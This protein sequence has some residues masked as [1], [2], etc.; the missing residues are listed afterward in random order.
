MVY[1]HYGD[2]LPVVGVL[3]R[4]LNECRQMDVRL[5]GVEELVED[6]V[7]GIRTRTAF[8]DAQ[9]ALGLRD[10]SGVVGPVTW[11]QLA[12]IGGFRIVDVVDAVFEAW[13]Q[14]KGRAG[15][16]WEQID[17]YMKKFP[18]RSQSDAV[19]FADRAIRSMENEI[20]DNRNQYN[21][22]V[23]H[24]GRPIAITSRE[25]VFAAIRKGLEERCRDGNRVV[26]LRF[27][28]HGGPGSQGVAATTS[29]RRVRIT[30]DTLSFDD[31]DTPEELVETVVL[32]GMTMPMAS[33]GCVELHGCNVGARRRVGR[34]KDRILVNGPAYVQNFANTVG[35][36]VSASAIG[37]YF[38]TLK[39]DV[40]Y[41]GAV[42][43]CAPGGASVRDWFK[44]H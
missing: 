15:L 24:G 4:V 19:A 2:R 31:D 36:P 14:K 23:T 1:L 29:A 18:H 37:D 25:H 28:A 22:L 6:G 17:L 41:E 27:T 30:D 10:Q 13:M 16:H 42:V 32:S 33:F 40:R 5:F 7:F 12:T 20:K 35:R 39:L 9:V 44:Q 11:R 43:S 38:G 26:L 34:G 3:Q 8:Q 21:R